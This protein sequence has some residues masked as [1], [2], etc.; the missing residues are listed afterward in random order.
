MNWS[1]SLQ[2][3]RLNSDCRFPIMPFGHST[4]ILIGEKPKTGAELV[5]YWQNEGLIGTRPD[6]LDS[7]AHARQICEQAERR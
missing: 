6:R 5:A 3:K 1:K 2:P 4:G 7:Q